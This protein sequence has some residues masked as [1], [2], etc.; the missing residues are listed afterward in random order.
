VTA[1]L[2]GPWA[3][4]ARSFSVSAQAEPPA[5]SAD[6]LRKPTDRA[7]PE[8]PL[9]EQSAP[10][11]TLLQTP[12][13]PPLGFAGKSGITPRDVQETSHFVPVEDRWRIGYPDWDRYGNGHPWTDDY[14]YVLGSLWDPYNLN[15]LKGDYPLIGQHTFLEITASSISFLEARQV[16]TGTTPFE[17]TTRPFREEFFGSPNQFFYNQLLSVSF[18]LFHG[19][20]AFKPADWR[21]HLTPTFNVNNIAVDE[22][23]V[24]SPDVREGTQRGRTFFTLEEYFAEVKLADTSPDYDFTSL[25]IGQQFFQSDFRGFLFRDTNR[26]VRLF[27]TRDAN[28]D[29]FNVAYFRQ[30]EKDTNSGLNTFNDRGQ[31]VFVANYYH[32][33][34]IWPGYTAQVSVTYNH[35]P[36]SFHFDQ[37]KF[38]VR[39]DPVGVFQPHDIKVVYLGW[40]GDGHINRYNISHQLYWALGHDSLNPLAGRPQDISA[41]MGACELS[42]DRDWAR[43]RVSM[44]YASGDDDLTNKHA[45]GFDTILDS[46]DFAGGRFSYWQRQQLQL[47]GVNLVNRESLVP[48]LRSS[49]LQGQTNFVN[50]GLWLVNAGVDFD[51]TPKLR[52]IN[53]INFLWFDETAPLETFLFDGNIRRYIGMDISTGVEYRPLLSNNIIVT[54]GLATLI[55]GGGFKDLYDRLRDPVNPFIAGFLE[56][57]LTY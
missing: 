38:L 10:T 30:A 47:F 53:N 20:A 49:K 5:Q 24:V 14:P 51:L 41:L 32:Q 45:T 15:V 52:M 48:D 35:D 55:P 17:S 23:A 36:R 25:R 21:V 29:Q 43:F 37:N 1:A 19:D 4:P 56:V 12:V 11:D 2:V 22:L 44:F 28:R 13:D 8:P 39:P 9:A 7:T 31:D 33:D 46:P 34:F 54:A 50:P 6:R 27:G 42:Y 57:A 3:V 18:D 26:A 40:A 16:P